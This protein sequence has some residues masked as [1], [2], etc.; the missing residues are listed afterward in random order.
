MIPQE[1]I[2]EILAKVRIE[3]IIQEYLPL[4]KK[5][6]D[7]LTICPFHDDKNPSLSISPKKQIFKCF[8]CGESGNAISFVQKYENISFPEA[9]AKVGEKVGIHIDYKKR[10]I[11]LSPE[12]IISR[13]IVSQVE[14]FA[15]YNLFLEENKHILKHLIEERNLNE[16]TIRKFKIGYIPSSDKLYVFLRA[17]GY[18][19]QQMKEAGI[20]Q[21]DLDKLYSFMDKRISFPIQDI[22]DNTIG[23]SC[24]KLAEDTGPKYINSSENI[25]FHKSDVLFNYSKA[26]RSALLKKEIIVMEG[27]MDVIKASKL[28]IENCVAQM[29]TALS[30][31]QIKLLKKM[32]M[33]VK[34]VYDGDSAGQITTH[35]NYELL[36]KADIEVK[37]I[38]LPNEMDPDEMMDK[39]PQEFIHHINKKD[40]ILDYQLNQIIDKKDF[41]TIERY[42]VSFMK[43][44]ISLN[45]PLAE[46]FYLHKLSSKTGFQT[47]SL[48]QKLDLM[49]P[50]KV[51]MNVKINKKS[52]NPTKWTPKKHIK[53][54]LRV[55]SKMEFKE[56]VSQNFDRLKETNQVKVFDENNLLSRKDLL[57]KYC[58]L[59]GKVLETTVTLINYDNVDAVAQSVASSINKE[60]AKVLDIP[61]SNL[62]YIAFLHTDSK[63][64]HL[65]IQ[66]YQ[67]ET[68]LDNYALTNQLVNTI[69]NTIADE[70]NKISDIALEPNFQSIGM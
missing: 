6:N 36:K 46:D 11:S 44:L 62:D 15:S 69:E 7:Y 61:M 20:F 68:Y 66:M 67:K 29:G 38:L 10:N 1:T 19:F 49:K 31:N 51:N 23:F 54:N 28:G 21:G 25:L 37:T 2:N 65:H 8:A 30:D 27:Q 24:R 14:E 52:N 64:P 55:K 12:K 35:K 53:V 59:K 50:Q 33:P 56:E 60:V 17:K 4:T 26:K 5:G 34:L 40:M 13:N 43:K 9:V 22:E 57:K 70:L 3:E 47:E 48:K 16:E 39:E 58:E 18:N 41:D 32:K 63:H 42:T 45:N